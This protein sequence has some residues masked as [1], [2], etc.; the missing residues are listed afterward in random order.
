[1][2]IGVYTYFQISVFIFFVHILRSAIAGS[3][4]SSIFSFLRNL[5]IAFHSV[6]SDKGSKIYKEFI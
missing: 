2:N 4:G 1:M 5:H 6:M 3:Y